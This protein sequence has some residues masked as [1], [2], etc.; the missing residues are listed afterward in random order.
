MICFSVLLIDV[1]EYTTKFLF[2]SQK[3]KSF[4]PNYI[5]IYIL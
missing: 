1:L 3:Y 4:D 5:Y 2:P